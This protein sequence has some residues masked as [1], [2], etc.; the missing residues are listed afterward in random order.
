[1]TLRLILRGLLIIVALTLCSYL[2]KSLVDAA[3]IDAHVRGHG[4]PGELLFLLTGLLP[5]GIFELPPLIMGEAVALSFGIAVLRGIFGKD[6]QDIIKSNLKSNLKYLAV[7]A[8]LFITAA[9]IETFVT[10][11]LLDRIA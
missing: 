7:S 11:V 2:L 3:W 1:M 4:I 5:H 10:P 6:K 9:I 8:G